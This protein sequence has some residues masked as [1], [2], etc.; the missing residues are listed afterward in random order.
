MIIISFSKLSQLNYVKLC[1]GYVVVFTA[2]CAMYVV[3][4]SVYPMSVCEG[5]SCYIQYI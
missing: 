5:A 3:K 1:D 4:M 2:L